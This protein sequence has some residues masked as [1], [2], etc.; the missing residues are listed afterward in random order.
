MSGK[1]LK[2]L[3]QEQKKAVMFGEGPLLILAGAGSGKTRA[4]T[5]RAAYLI[6]EKGV[7]PEQVLLVT[8]TNKAAGEMKSRLKK[9]IEGPELP[10]AGTFHAFC[11]RLLRTDGRQID[12]PAGFVIYDEDDSLETI[13]QA[14]SKLKLSTD[15]YKPRGVKTVISQAKNEL[16]SALEYPQYAR[17]HFQEGV[18]K[19]YLEYQRLLKLYQA[20]DFDDLLFE[21]VRL[22]E[23][24]KEVRSK[25][26]LQYHYLLVDEYQDTNRAQYLLSKILAAKWRNLC[27]VGDAAQSIYSWR[28]ADYRNLDNLKNDFTD[29]TVINLEQ[30]YRS[31][32][33]I[34]EAANQVISKNTLHPILQLWTKTKQGSKITIFEAEDEKD[35]A[36][37]M[38][39]TIK[40]GVR[41]GAELNDY[42]I[43]YRTNAQSRIVE[44]ALIKASLPY[45]LIG[46]VRF[47]GRKEI[48]DCLAY[49]R[50]L[51]NPKD[52]V[53]Y[54][55]I[56]K[57]GQRRLGRFLDWVEKLKKKKMPKTLEILDELLKVTSYLE[58][59]DEKNE[60][61]LMRLENIK[62][63]R[64]VAAEFEQLDE[65]L[66]NVALV[67]QTDWL[68]EKPKKNEAK[69]KAVILMTLH[70]AKGLEFETVFMVGMEEGLCPH[71]RSMIDK[72]E[73]E[74]E[75][76]LFYVGMTRA[77]KELCISYAQQRLYFGRRSRNQVSRFLLDID[78]GLLNMRGRE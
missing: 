67:E 33:N 68:P 45:V 9:L 36:R 21:A 10:W 50:F 19:I 7:K 26:Q 12:I 57:L 75:R 22:L 27:V 70:A 62:E 71:A 56:E 25:Y 55:R 44:E 3:N 20:L 66:E 16:I 78:D 52:Q 14:I 74:E 8:F 60:Q 76:R 40:K 54:K 72:H 28:G 31:S 47:Y 17:G 6:K 39:Q 59:F 41:A 15:L 32:Q 2:D 42:A 58:R 61:D 18:S 77:K 37:F 29:L 53:S 23:Q 64:S 30:N 69:K 24:S 46:G 43:L 63:L 65:F 34:L 11:S 38:A 13:K 73:L 51:V 1:L 4:L 5:R 35:E 48:K 49:L